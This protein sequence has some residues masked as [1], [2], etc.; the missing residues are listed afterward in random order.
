[1][2]TP[3]ERVEIVIGHS[4][5]RATGRRQTPARVDPVGSLEWFG[6]AE[7]SNIELM[8]RIRKRRFSPARL[9]IPD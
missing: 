4:P 6:N 1:L 9:G 3:N 5:E 7:I 2:T 8:H